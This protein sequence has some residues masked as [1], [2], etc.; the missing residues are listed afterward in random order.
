MGSKTYY[1]LKTNGAAPNARTITKFDSDLEVVSSY[2]M[3]YFEGNGRSYYDCACPAS[4]FDCRHKTI[5]AEIEARGG[6]DSPK[7]FCFE[8]KM[9]YRADQVQ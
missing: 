5:R 9:M 6:L 4:K 7:F 8:D 1:Q 3:T 2:Y